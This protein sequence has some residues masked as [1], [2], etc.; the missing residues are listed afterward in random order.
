MVGNN[1]TTS[2]SWLLGVDSVLDPEASSFDS[3][4]QDGSIL[5][6]SNTTKEND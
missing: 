6:I 5:V 1:N 2:S 4:V 3:I